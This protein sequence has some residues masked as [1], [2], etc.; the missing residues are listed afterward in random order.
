VFGVRWRW[1]ATTALALPRFVGGR[2]VAPQLQRMKSEDLLATVFPDQVA[3]AENLVGEREVPDHP[4]VAQTLDDCL[5]E[6]MDTEGWLALLRKLE[7]GEVE[8]VARD[9]TAPS[10][11]AAEALNARPY[12]FLDDAPLEERRTQA[13]MSRRY[14]DADSAGDLGRLDPD[15]IAQV[16]EQAWPQARNADEMHDALMGLGCVGA[17]EA[18]ANAGWAELLRKLAKDH[19]A[20][21][22]DAGASLWFAAERLPQAQALYPGVAHAPAIEAPAEFA[23][24]PWTREAAL[25]ELLRARLTGLGPVAAGALADALALPQL[26]VDMALLKLEG[27]GFAMRGRFT[28]GTQAEEWCERNL[29]ARIHRYTIGR[30]RKEI[31]PVEQRDFMR[32][33]FDWQRVS[34]AT[35]VSGPEALAGVLAQLEGFEAPAG[36]WESELL[37][38]RVADYSLSWLDDLCT[39]G[40]VTWTRLRGIPAVAEGNNA[41]SA[42]VRSTPIALL[43]RRQL[44]LWTQVTAGQHEDEPALSTRAEK[45]AGYLREHGA[46]FFDELVSGAHLLRTELEDAL[47][48]LVARGRVHCDSFAGLR[49]LLVPQSKRPSAFNRRGRRAALFGIEDAGRWTLTRRDVAATP[50]ARPEPETIEHIARTLLR[51]YGV[52]CWRLLERE[53]AWLPP[54]RDLLRVYHR[55]EARGEIRGGRFVAGLS[56]EQFALP[57]AVGALRQVRR[58]APDAEMLAL[59]AS[60]PLNLV[61]TVLPGSKVPRLPGARVLY[62]DGIALATLVAGTV[63]LLQPLSDA[64]AHAARR[65]LLR[66]PESMPAIV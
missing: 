58:Q 24:Q 60:D 28:P 63:E 11:F 25:V 2:K 48:E 38:A 14:A 59:S 10:P 34:K 23:Q 47:A 40:R 55:L 45:V 3:C 65:M 44:A 64:D 29:L 61:G 26:D 32:F 41:R 12:A 51:R 18:L 54:W 15:A 9:L 46:S 56:G 33:L 13:V 21:R 27:E 5:H 50:T 39:A 19:R 31:E 43:P 8:I 35:R 1:N 52:V 20:T 62:R 6:A 36:A 42:P 17:R 66:E 30:L 57:E 16:R 4:L 7:S 37:P 53:A 22:I 49:A